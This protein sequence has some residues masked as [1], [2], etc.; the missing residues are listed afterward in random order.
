MGQD[1]AIKTMSHSMWLQMKAGKGSTVW[2]MKKHLQ[3]LNKVD[4]L[5]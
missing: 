4:F 1:Q 2:T 3:T 5:F